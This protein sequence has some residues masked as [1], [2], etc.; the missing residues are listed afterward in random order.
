MA[1]V[2]GRVWEIH[3][4]EVLDLHVANTNNQTDE[5]DDDNRFNDDAA[6]PDGESFPFISP[7]LGPVFTTPPPGKKQSGTHRPDD[8]SKPKEPPA[9][10]AG[11]N[12]FLV[13]MNSQLVT[14]LTSVVG[15]LSAALVQRPPP[16]TPPPSQAQSGPSTDAPGAPRLNAAELAAFLKAAASPAASGN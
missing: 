2:V 6:L 1:E 13:S 12:N 3:L 9:P 15:N 14:S 16:A 8:G 5:D 11:V 10:Q 7:P 4:G